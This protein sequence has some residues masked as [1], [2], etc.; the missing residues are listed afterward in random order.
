M[1]VGSTRHA[2]VSV[3][4]LS[5]EKWQP[6]TMDRRQTAIMPSKQI[7]VVPRQ[8]TAMM[9]CKVKWQLPCGNLYLCNG[10]R[11]ADRISMTG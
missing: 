10:G 5:G 4:L 8:E 6:D 1:Q 11:E 2:T 3:K 7:S 9:G